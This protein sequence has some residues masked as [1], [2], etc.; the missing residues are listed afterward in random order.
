MIEGAAVHADHR[1]LRVGV[2][3]GVAVPGEVLRTRRHPGPLDAADVRR[4]VPGDQVSVRSEA[5]DADHRVAR[6]AVDVGVRGEVEVDP[7][8]PEFGTD[9]V[10]G[11]FG[12]GHRI[13]AA[14]E[15]RGGMR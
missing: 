1:Q 12:R 8:L 9:R 13:L 5:A 3:G 10:A 14:E 4:D 6:V 2:G 15:R 7:G 11:G